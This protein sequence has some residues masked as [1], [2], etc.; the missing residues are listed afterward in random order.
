[1]KLLSSMTLAL[2]LVFSVLSISQEAEAYGSYHSYSSF[3][4]GSNGFMLEANGIYYFTTEGGNPPNNPNT[5]VTRELLDALFGYHFNLFFIGANYSYDAIVTSGNN[6]ATSTDSF[7]GYGADF[8][9]ITQGVELIF[10]YY[11][12]GN[13]TRLG[14]IPGSVV[15]YTN[16]SG[17]Q[18]RLGYLFDV[19]S[20]WAIGPS[21]TYKSLTYS[22]TNNISANFTYTTLV[23]EASVKYNF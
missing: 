10:T 22:T 6:S 14:G 23:P 7:R 5:T 21:L 9:I 8:G 19:G 13:G 4:D 17:Y 3:S 11:F 1:M 12:M 2:V 15:D 20:G 18:I 16:G